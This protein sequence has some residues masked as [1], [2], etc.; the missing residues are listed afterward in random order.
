MRLI[1]LGPPGAG[2]GTQAVRLAERFAVPHVATGDLLRFAVK[3]QTEIGLRAQSYMEA[4][5]LVPDEIVLELLRRRLSEP[6]AQQGFVM[7]GYPRNPAQANALEEILTEVGSTLDAVVSLEV[8]DEIIVERLSARWSCPTC[9]RTYKEPGACRVDSTPLFQRDDDKPE[10]I[11]H[12]LKIFHAQTQPLIAYYETR[13][14]LVH[15]D[16]VGSLDEVEERIAKAMVS[17]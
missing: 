4:G 14:L 7:D 11:R 6:D 8:D 2:K 12:R 3:W 17:K 16:G 1:L 10:V 15:V 5:E 9:G 13:G